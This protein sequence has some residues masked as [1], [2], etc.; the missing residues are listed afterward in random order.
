[1]NKKNE[2]GKEGAKNRGV[3]MCIV[4]VTSRDKNRVLKHQ[5]RLDDLN[6]RTGI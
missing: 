2:E 1:M 3:K 5:R 4:W 6:Q